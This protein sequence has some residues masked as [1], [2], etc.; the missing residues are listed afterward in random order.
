MP[1]RIWVQVKPHAKKTTLTALDGDTY[2][3]SVHAPPQDGKA[4]E[5]LIELLAEHFS[6][7]KSKF[8]IL[9]GHSARKKLIELG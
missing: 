9:H 2:Q 3:A 6:L 1:R 5:A 8:K 4:N 7:P